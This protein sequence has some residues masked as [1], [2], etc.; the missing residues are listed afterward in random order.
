MKIISV[1]IISF[2][3]FFSLNAQDLTYID[4]TQAKFEIKNAE[5][6]FEDFQIVPLE[7]HPE[8]LLKFETADFYLTDRYIIGMHTFGPACLF[9][10]KTG[11]FIREISSRGRGPD[12]YAAILYGKYGFDEEN[13]I[14]L[15]TTYM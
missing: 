13:N 10:R 2:V 15:K 9:D 4:I 5:E 14:L 7:T 8:G 11:A 3:V 12:E 6:I 1:A